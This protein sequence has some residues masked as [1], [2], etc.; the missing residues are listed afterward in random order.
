MSLVNPSHLE[1]RQPLWTLRG[2]AGEKPASEFR[3]IKLTV[4]LWKRRSTEGTDRE[5]KRE[6]AKLRVPDR[7]HPFRYKAV[8][9][10]LITRTP[11][12]SKYII[13]KTAI[14]GIRLS[15]A[16]AVEVLGNGPV[17]ALQIL[18]VGCLRCRSKGPELNP[19]PPR[20]K[21]PHPKITKWCDMLCGEYL[22]RIRGEAKGL[23][24]VGLNFKGFAVGRFRLQ[25]FRVSPLHSPNSPKTVW[26][27]VDPKP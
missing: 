2:Y 20:I 12:E 8:W 14:V 24:L 22:L 1:V 3:T 17:L 7:T 26:E 18:Q 13:H 6:P 15:T 11:H 10:G 9:G 4:P 25:G 23:G 19:R 16:M 27:G 21:P 5:T